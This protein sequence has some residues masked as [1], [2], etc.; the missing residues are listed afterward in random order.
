MHPIVL[1][2]QNKASLSEIYV[3]GDNMIN[4]QSCVLMVDV[5][6]GLDEQDVP[7]K[8]IQNQELNANNVQSLNLLFGA[9]G[10][11]H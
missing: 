8:W 3:H 1:K 9:R 10:K 6:L 2:K 11:T 7:A 4:D 5:W